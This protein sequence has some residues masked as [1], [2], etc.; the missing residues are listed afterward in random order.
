MSTMET[1]KE[2]AAD[3]LNEIDDLIETAGDDLSEESHDDLID[4]A[5]VISAFLGVES[6]D[7]TPE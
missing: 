1:V 2:K 6:E 7:E 5:E 3:L 4:V